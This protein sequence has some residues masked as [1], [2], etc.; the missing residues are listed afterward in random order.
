MRTPT[1]SNDFSIDSSDCVGTVATRRRRPAPTPTPLISRKT[2]VK[3]EE[4]PGKSFFNFQDTISRTAVSES[5]NESKS[6]GSILAQESGKTTEARERRPLERRRPASTDSATASRESRGVPAPP[7][8][9]VL[10]G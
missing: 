10:G 6:I 5:G 7:T 1:L 2:I 3:S 8:P 4:T 9:T